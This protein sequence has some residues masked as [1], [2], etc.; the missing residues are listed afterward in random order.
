MVGDSSCRVFHTIFFSSKNLL[1]SICLQG[2]FTFIVDMLICL[3]SLRNSLGSEPTE[4]VWPCLAVIY[5]L[6][7]KI[8]SWLL[9]QI[10][11]C[12]FDLQ[13]FSFR[14]LE[15]LIC[16][17]GYTMG[18]FLYLLLTEMLLFEEKNFHAFGR[19]HVMRVN[20]KWIDYVINITI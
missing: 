14:F 3:W 12:C 18:I 10:Q 8:C 15:F 6:T 2:F 9:E 16:L 1:R 11:P 20:G 5:L 7:Y 17:R 4:T 13:G 19:K